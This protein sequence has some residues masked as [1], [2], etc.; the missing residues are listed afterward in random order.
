MPMAAN[1]KVVTSEGF[2]I[3]SPKKLSIA[4]EMEQRRAEQQNKNEISFDDT[5]S[6]ITPK[7][8]EACRRLEASGYNFSIKT[9]HVVKIEHVNY[10]PGTGKIWIDG[11]GPAFKSKG[12]ESLM[13][14]LKIEIRGR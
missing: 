6:E 12:L 7:M 9:E 2:T 8:M 14:L 11:A 5:I 1:L 13:E 3:G 10:A 4:E